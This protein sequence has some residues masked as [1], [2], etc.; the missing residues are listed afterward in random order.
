MKT[1]AA[2]VRSTAGRAAVVVAMV[3][4]FLA[5]MVA[6]TAFADS[7]SAQSSG[8]AA[9]YTPGQ[10]SGGDGNG[11]PGYQPGEYSSE[12]APTGVGNGQPGYQPGEYSEARGQMLMEKYGIPEYQPGWKPG[13]PYVPGA[14]SGEQE[15]H[16]NWA[17]EM[18]WRMNPQ[19]QRDW[20]DLNGIGCGGY[21]GSSANSQC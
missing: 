13:D 12:G 1:T 5:T 19:D 16:D 10:Y 14:I 9:D 8:R 3:A 15:R 2:T 7:T 17:R 20:Y 11:I 18:G 4:A 6:G 21:R